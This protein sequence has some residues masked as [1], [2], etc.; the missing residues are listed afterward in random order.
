[1]S[2]LIKHA[3]KE[4]DLIYS[5]E[6]LKHG[7]NK[8]AYD[9]IM[10]LIKVFSKQ[11][12]SNNSAGYVVSAFKTLAMFETIV[13]LTGED[14]EWRLIADEPEPK[15]QNIRNSAVFK[16]SDGTAYFIDAVV[17]KEKGGCCFVNKDSRMAVKFPVVPKTFYVDRYED[18]SYNKE[19]YEEAVRYYEHGN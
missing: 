14:D 6:D 17:W 7:I 2:N 4:L 1:M 9:A 10:E 3:K 13:P 15:W 8:Y 18:E 12:H 16:E 19:Q 5:K 11:G